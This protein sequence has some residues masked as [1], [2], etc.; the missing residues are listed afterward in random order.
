MNKKF[1]GCYNHSVILT[2]FGIFIALLGI[3]NVENLHTSMLCLI[4]AGICDLYDGAIARK[5]KRTDL[6]KEFGKE[7]DSLADVIGS[8]ALPFFILIEV[9]QR[10]EINIIFGILI[11]ILYVLMGITRLAWFNITTDLK[12]IEEDKKYYR[13][14]YYQGMPVTYAALVFP[15]LYLFFRTFS[16]FGVILCI[17]YIIMSFLFVFNLKIKKPTCGWYIFFT[18][19]ALFVMLVLYLDR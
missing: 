3:I 8:L 19:L 10:Y 11:G 16:S 6:E 2:Y 7:I 17:S 14:Q 4:M 9:C 13:T 18:L 12:K 15:L 1:I 5:V